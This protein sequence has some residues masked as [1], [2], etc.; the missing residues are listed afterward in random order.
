M[1]MSLSLAA[2]V[3]SSAVACGENPGPRPELPTSL[4]LVTLDTLRADRV[5][6]YGATDVQTPNLDRLAREG[7][8]FA[9]AVS[10]APLTLP[11]HA[12]LLTGL[13]PDRHG[14]R[15]NGAGRLAQDI[16]TLAGRLTAAGYRSGA[17]T[18]A[19]VLDRRFG[20]DRGF[21]HYDDEVPR[22]PGG[23]AALEAERPGRE[24]TNR[25]LAWLREAPEQPFFAWVH[26]YDA[27]APYEP[28]EPF[29]SAF[30]GRPY[31]GEVAAVD[32]EVGRLIA[33]LTRLGLDRRTLVAV[34]G[35]HGEA[36]GEHGELTHGLLLYEGSLSVP[37]LLRAPG[38]L[39]AGQVVRTPV[40]IVDLGP[41]L[42]G[43]VGEPL[44]SG[45]QPTLDGRNLSRVLRSGGEPPPSDVHSE[46]LYPAVMGWSP[47]ASLR[48]GD[49][50]Y[51]ASPEAELFDLARD[52]GETANLVGQRPDAARDMA[53]AI[54][55]RCR[56][57][58]PAESTATVDAETRAMLAQLGYVTSSEPP[59]PAG[60]AADP[61]RMVGLFSR[62]EEAHWALLDGRLDAARPALEELVRADPANPVFRA[63][64]AEV[65]RRSGELDRAVDTYR[66]AVA[67]APEDPEALYNLGV[68]L[69]EAGRASEAVVALRHS[70]ELGPDRSEAHNAL[71]VALSLTGD[72]AAA[73]EQFRQAAAADPRDAS[74][75]N[76]LGNVCRDLGRG[77][78]AESAY[79]RAIEL[80]PSYADPWNGLGALEVSRHNPGAAIPHFDRALELAPD[81]LEVELN[82]GIALEESGDRA[83]AAAAYR[84]FL[85]R[86][87]DDPRYGTLRQAAS[88]LLAR[89]E[90]LPTS[91]SGKGGLTSGQSS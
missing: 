37:C 10:P 2:I 21:D 78:Q 47:I 63:Q 66:E 25:A 76:N 90:G 79:R 34:V 85:A 89:L 4:L 13:L 18:G 83:G 17:F 61:K 84:D 27:H 39:A 46:S 43:L 67:A 41:T 28:P 69:Q 62:F 51:I 58:E 7:V 35:D 52:P 75:F 86:S 6:A 20:L 23:I 24:V 87:Q 45:P 74:A 26:L 32:A 65:F 70:L 57:D 30:P 49:L 59:T 50:K 19:F 38:L 48:R 29:R 71:G 44:E 54:A 64:L 42:A 88:Q 8:R 22:S 55:A 77:D 68:T 11:A 1:R 36:L 73:A 16:P 12:S 3:L 15:N 14:L 33:E 80:D 31:D 60:P 53:A 5:G 40:G 9:H 82:L 72:L 91:D 56:T 81:R